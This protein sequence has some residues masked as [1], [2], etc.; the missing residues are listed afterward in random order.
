MAN[1]KQS[2]KMEMEC[3]E[4]GRKFSASAKRSEPR[5]K[6]GSVDLEIAEAV[7]AAPVKSYSVPSMNSKGGTVRVTVPDYY[8]NHSDA[9]GGL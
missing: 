2:E 7:I 5:C 1:K 3:M 4:C 8:E 9:D 6:C